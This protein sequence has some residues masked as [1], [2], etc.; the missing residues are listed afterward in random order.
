MD[1]DGEGVVYKNVADEAP[2]PSSASAPD[3]EGKYWRQ[4]A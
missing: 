4:V 2:S 3:R 1:C